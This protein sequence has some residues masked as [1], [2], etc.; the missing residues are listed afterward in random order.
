M[1]NTK[2]S[3]KNVRILF[4][5]V[6]VF[7]FASF[8]YAEE[9]SDEGT[10][11]ISGYVH[12][13]I[14]GDT[15][16]LYEFGETDFD[17]SYV[18]E[19]DGYYEFTNI[20]P[21]T[22]SLYIPSPPEEYY[23]YKGA[24][25]DIFANT[26]LTNF[27]I[28]LSP[29]NNS[30]NID[31]IS[32]SLYELHSKKEVVEIAEEYGSLLMSYYSYSNH[33]SVSLPASKT[34]EETIALYEADPRVENA[35]FSKYSNVALGVSPEENNETTENISVITTNISVEEDVVQEEEIIPNNKEEKSWFRKIIDM[36]KALFV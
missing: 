36:L 3:L 29:R 2:R 9:N 11:S 32:I 14:E 15:V 12:P 33:Y 13:I 35:Y 21:G 27:N 10:G 23:I 19:A 4:F 8:V 20:K 6:V 18:I 5:I 22:Y 26:T 24:I 1:K 31:R 28:T 25:L 34:I 16:N 30:Y 17:D 7:S